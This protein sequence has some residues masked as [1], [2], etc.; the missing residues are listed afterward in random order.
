[1]MWWMCNPT[2]VCSKMARR[3]PPKEYTT[4][5]WIRKTNPTIRAGTENSTC[6]CHFQ[7]TPD[8]SSCFLQASIWSLDLDSH[9]AAYPTL[10]TVIIV[11]RNIGHAT[12]KSPVAQS[13]H[14]RY[15]STQ[16]RNVTFIPHK[17]EEYA[18]NNLIQ[19]HFQMWYDG[20]SC[21]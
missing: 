17:N 12:K 1:M 20:W 4:L 8:T 2:K 14:H 3:D 16:R 9:P 19:L 13:T 5:Q 11:K 6:C 21:E 7:S 18:P 15:P 10:W